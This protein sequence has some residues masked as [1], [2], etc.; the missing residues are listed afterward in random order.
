MKGKEIGKVFHYFGHIGVAAIELSDSLKLGDTIRFIGG[1]HDFTEV[2]DS[3]QIERENVTS[4]RA[5]EKVG[6]KVSEAINKGAKV[7]KV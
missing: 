1:E 5:G 3:I 4:A 2:V 6:L 7:Y